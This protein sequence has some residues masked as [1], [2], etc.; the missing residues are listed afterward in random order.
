[1]KILVTGGLGFIG[2]ITCIYLLEKG[3]DVVIIDNLSNSKIEVLDKIKKITHKNITF[4]KKDLKNKQDID[5]IFLNEKIDACIHFAGY[6]AVFES[7]V[8]PLKYYNN[9]LISTI[10]LLEVMKKYNVKKL[11]FSSS[12][13]VYGKPKSLP[14]YEDFP[15]S[16]NNPYGNT[17]LI[18]ENILSDLFKSDN[19]FSIAILRYFNPIGGDE[20]GLLYEDPNEVP[21][22]LMPYIVKVAS[23]QLPFLKVFGNDYETID[24]TGVRDYIHVVDLAKGHINALEYIMNK[25]CLETFNLGTGVGTSVLELVKIFEEVNNVEIPYKIEKRRDGDVESCY[26]SIDKAVKL[27]NFKPTKTIYDACY[28]SYRYIKE[29]KNDAV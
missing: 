6:K 29:G 12:A 16:S 2:S 23:K 21:N 5:D 4:Y 24:G 20:S 28:D 9:N 10:N 22:N 1:M 26:A 18:I 8:D 25:T 11:V 13:T 17:K 19:S 15:L 3:F 7:V 27:L 14:I